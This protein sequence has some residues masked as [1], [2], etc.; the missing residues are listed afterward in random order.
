[1][2]GRE[3]MSSV[4]RAWLM[5]DD[6]TNPMVINGFWIF[7]EPLLYE[8]VLAV[9]EERLLIHARFRQRVVEHRGALRPRAYWEV[10]PEFDL[11]AH[12]GRIVLP[13]PGDK[14]ALNDT[15]ARLLIAPLDLNRPLWRF[16][17]IEGYGGGSVFFGRIHH[18]IGD[19]AAL[20]R[21]LLSL[22]DGSAQGARRAPVAAAGPPQKGTS[23]AP[24][25]DS[26]RDGDIA[27]RP[28]GGQTAGQSSVS[29][30]K[31]R[32]AGWEA[33]RCVSQAGVDDN[34]R[35]N[36]FQRCGWGRQSGCLVQGDSL[37]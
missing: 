14:K 22:T 28:Q 15:V 30:G 21:V 11:R 5:M 1:M 17:L 13:S 2:A 37:G 23:R 4:D 31:G 6:P 26:S 8:Q 27:A 18:C 7:E 33:H 25:R 32:T 10:D 19:G 29:G 12:V 9:L 3:P 34:G 24:R 36:G 16:T 20:V 35:Q